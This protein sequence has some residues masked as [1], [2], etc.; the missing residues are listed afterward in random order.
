LI[1]AMRR[2]YMYIFL[3]EV[4]WRGTPLNSFPGWCSIARNNRPT[5]Y[6]HR[7]PA[8]HFS[9]SIETPAHSCM[10]QIP[11]VTRN[12][13]EGEAVLNWLWLP[14]ASNGLTLWLSP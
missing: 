13:Q 12:S 2:I 1:S 9:E 7:L 4:G 10:A 14:F 6:T 5:P 11:V 8:L 3:R